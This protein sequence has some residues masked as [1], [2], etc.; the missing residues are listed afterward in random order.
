MSLLM[1]K[2]SSEQLLKDF[3]ILQNSIANYE[4]IYG[5]LC[6]KIYSLRQETLMA[7]PFEV[8]EPASV[9]K[10]PVLPRAKFILIICMISGLI[11]GVIGAFIR[12][13]WL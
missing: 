9:P 5:N 10:Q 8:F 6:N 7:R 1:K 11:T 2:L 3:P 13:A 12:E 4:G